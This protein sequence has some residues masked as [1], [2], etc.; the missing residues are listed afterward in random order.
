MRRFFRLEGS[1]GGLRYEARL[2]I[3]DLTVM[4]ES[5]SGREAGRVSLMKRLIGWRASDDSLEADLRVWE[6]EGGAFL[7]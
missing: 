7:N 3:L 2:K 4:A 1:F 6:S 5:L